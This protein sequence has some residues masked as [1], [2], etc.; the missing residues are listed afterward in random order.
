MTRKVQKGPRV[1]IAHHFSAFAAAKI[2]TPATSTPREGAPPRAPSAT[3]ARKA[4]G[5][6][7]RINAYTSPG[8]SMPPRARCARWFAAARRASISIDPNTTARTMNGIRRTA[9]GQVRL[10]A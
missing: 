9:D 6:A 2:E 7:M 1:R 4:A 5:Y 3:I 8:G 10:R